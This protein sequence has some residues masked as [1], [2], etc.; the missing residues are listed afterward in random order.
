MKPNSPIDLIS[1]PKCSCFLPLGWKCWNHLRWLPSLP[2]ALPLSKKRGSDKNGH[3]TGSNT[4]RPG[5][6]NFFSRSMVE[7]RTKKEFSSSNPAK[8]APGE[9]RNKLSSTWYWTD[10]WSKAVRCFW[11][12]RHSLLHQE[13]WHTSRSFP[14]EESRYPWAHC[15]TFCYPRWEVLLLVGCLNVLMLWRQSDKL[16]NHCP[17]WS[18]PKRETLNQWSSV[19]WNSLL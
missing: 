16:V 11:P 8:A 14:G 18:F 13:N 4:L 1:L 15:Y 5:Q 6:V 19:L 7:R 9:R 3:W 17:H 10:G 2:P 12:G